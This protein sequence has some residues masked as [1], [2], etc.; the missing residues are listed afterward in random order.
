[1]KPAEPYSKALKPKFRRPRDTRGKGFSKDFDN[2]TITT[3]PSL[4]CVKN[5][6]QIKSRKSRALRLSV[7]AVKTISFDGMGYILF[8]LFFSL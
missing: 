8:I 4:Y 6:H 7:R 5:Q 1:M 3:K 2:M